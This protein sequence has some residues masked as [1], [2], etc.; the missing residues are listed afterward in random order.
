MSCPARGLKFGTLL[1][2]MAMLALTGFFVPVGVDASVGT[3]SCDPPQMWAT[4]P[5]APA[6]ALPAHPMVA[7]ASV[8]LDLPGTPRSVWY[9]GHLPRGARSTSG[10]IGPR[11]PRSSGPQARRGGPCGR[12]RLESVGRLT[13]PSTAP[14][15]L[16][17]PGA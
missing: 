7:S 14:P 13:S 15:F 4:G 1:P 16:R 6:A 12:E 11:L 3:A 9:R 2:V 10:A 5:E 8:L 17:T